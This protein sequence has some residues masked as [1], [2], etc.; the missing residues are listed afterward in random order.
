MGRPALESLASDQ[1]LSGPPGGGGG[2]ARTIP[3]QRQKALDAKRQDLVDARMRPPSSQGG[4]ADISEPLPPRFV[5]F[6]ESSRSGLAQPCKFGIIS[7]G[8]WR[9]A[10]TTGGRAARRFEAAAFRASAGARSCASR[11]SSDAETAA[12]ACVP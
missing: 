4:P 12:P 3:E 2:G 6:T 8:I 5:A 11:W 9:G 1:P 7:E 10:S